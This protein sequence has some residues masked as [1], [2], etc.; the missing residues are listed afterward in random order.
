M[1]A[2]K[3]SIGALVNKAAIKANAKFIRPIGALFL[4]NLTTPERI[5]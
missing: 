2:R 5:F 1:S 3:R 4:E